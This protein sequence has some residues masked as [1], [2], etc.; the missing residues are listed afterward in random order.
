MNDRLTLRRRGMPVESRRIDTAGDFGQVLDTLFDLQPP[1][2]AAALF[3]RVPR[4]LD[5]AF[6]PGS[7]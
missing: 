3:E 2:P 7:A 4:G 5:G 6:V 1:V